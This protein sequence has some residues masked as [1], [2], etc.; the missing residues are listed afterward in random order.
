[1][2]SP[3]T[4]TSRPSGSPNTSYQSPPTS[5]SAEPAR[6]RAASSTPGMSGRRSGS[7]LRCRV[8]AVARSRSYR[9]ARSS[10]IA[11]WPARAPRKA[12]SRSAT[13]SSYSSSNEPIRPPDTARSTCTRA[14]PSVT[15]P[16][17]SLARMSS[18]V[19]AP[20]ATGA[21]SATT[22]RTSAMLSASP[23]AAV[24][25]WSCSVRSTLRRSASSARRPV[26]DVGD[27]HRHAEHGALAGAG[28]EPLRLVVPELAG[29]RRGGRRCRSVT[30][31]PVSRTCRSRCST[32]TPSSPSS[33][34]GR[35]PMWSSI[36]SP[37]M[38]ASIRLIRR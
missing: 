36:G 6:N 9:R 22:R 1:M 33:S 26:G 14:R 16:G 23:S 38:S 3:T 30:I 32:A 2:T 35:R 11:H 7:R 18:A 27:Q 19:R 25:C 37:L 20:V 10:A 13:G 34:A 24:A 21:V 31:A 12:S 5:A 15:G 4:S 8:T 28:R 29:P 17:G